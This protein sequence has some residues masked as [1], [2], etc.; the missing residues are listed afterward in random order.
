MSLLSLPPELI[1]HILTFTPW[2]SILSFL[3]TTSYLTTNVL[4]PSDLRLLRRRFVNDLL[5][6]ERD[7]RVERGW[8]LH[9]D[10]PNGPWYMNYEYEDHECMVLMGFREDGF[11]S[12]PCYT[13][14]RIRDWRHF[15]TPNR[16][17]GRMV[18]QKDGAKRVCVQC[19][20]KRGVY[21]PGN[22]FFMYTVCRGCECL[23]SPWNGAKFDG[24]NVEK[25]EGSVPEKFD[26]FIE[27]RVGEDGEESWFDLHPE[28]ENFWWWDYSQ[29]CGGCTAAAG[30]TV[31]E[32]LDHKP[33]RDF[34]V[35][36]MKKKYVAQ[37]IASLERARENRAKRGISGPVGGL[38]I[39]A[40]KKMEDPFP[41]FKPPPSFF[42]TIWRSTYISNWREMREE[43]EKKEPI[44]SAY[45]GYNR[46]RPT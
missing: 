31:E 37:R 29:M 41:E 34:V 8:P 24:E 38:D 5:A 45:N 39:E 26:A 9:P 42:G 20:V 17:G 16:M 7:R 40:L 32:F 46:P 35:N 19:G 2:L 25:V 15:S 21:K 14:M 18:G 13:C 1:Y 11:G 6:W 43:Y 22:R 12:L 28:V 23:M 3:S 27:K 36:R 10:P 30:Y 44:G 4:S 33:K